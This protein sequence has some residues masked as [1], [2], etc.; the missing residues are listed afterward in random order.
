VQLL[1]GPLKRQFEE[2]QC[3]AAMAGDVNRAVPWRTWKFTTCNSVVSKET[4]PN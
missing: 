1:A 4:I 2:N 3:Y